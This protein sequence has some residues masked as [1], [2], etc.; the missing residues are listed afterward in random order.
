MNK[1]S[2]EDIFFHVLSSAS[3]FILLFYVQ[4]V[5]TLIK[6]KFPQTER[7][8]NIENGEEFLQETNHV[9]NQQGSHPEVIKEED[10]KCMEPETQK[11]VNC[12]THFSRQIM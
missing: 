6:H 12:G 3:D 11:E 1:C 4:C 5:W 9:M 2:I 8:Q 10:Q 7:T